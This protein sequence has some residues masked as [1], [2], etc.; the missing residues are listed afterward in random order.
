MDSLRK[1]RNSRYNP[2]YIR[3]IG[4]GALTVSVLYITLFSRTP[5]LVRTVKIVP[6][7]SLVQCFSEDYSK[8]ILII[9]NVLLFLPIGFILASLISHVF[10][11]GLLC[12]A[13]SVTIEGLQFF[14]YLGCFDID[15][16]IM[17][18]I[19]GLLGILLYLLLHKKIEKYMILVISSLM[20]LGI[21][22]SVFAPRTQHHFETQ[23]DFDICS[24]SV[25]DNTI[26]FEGVCYIYQ[27]S[28]VEYELLLK[29]DGETFC[30]K[31]IIDGNNYSAVVNVPAESDYEVFVKFT[32]YEA[33][34]TK[35]YI[36]NGRIKYVNRSVKPD[37]E[38]TD[39][40]T[41]VDRGTL[42]VY[43]PQFE[44]F[45]YQY[46][47][48]LYWIIGTDYDASI[49]Y[50]LHT[51]EPSKLPETRVKYGFDNKDFRKGGPQEIA[52]TIK[53]GRYKVY[54]D[55]IS[56]EYYVSAIMVGM[57]SEDGLLWSQYFRPNRF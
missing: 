56:K 23:F 1:D 29:N 11:S 12:L 2:L 15:D 54:S 5:G 35:V 19:G 20:V 46:K 52:E 26:T 13:L 31:T 38:G 33:L 36:D 7:W 32:G 42:K 24:V 45:V 57:S 34:S 18:L 22:E 47:D 28:N 25:V 27:R 16:I 4:L 44:V 39:L 9:L 14:T 49:I 17:N 43:E 21:V 55:T 51:S 10:L 40:E 6:F 48:R 3:M 8:S 37:V 41:I 50:H 30:A 53:C